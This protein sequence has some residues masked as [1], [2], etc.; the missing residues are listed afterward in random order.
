MSARFIEVRDNDEYLV[1]DLQ[2]PT[3]HVICRCS[4]FKAPL[5]AEYVCMA[6]EAYHSNL[7]SKVMG[8]AGTGYCDGGQG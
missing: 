5:F 7:Y 8:I 6:L 2:G 4:G 1:L 3:P